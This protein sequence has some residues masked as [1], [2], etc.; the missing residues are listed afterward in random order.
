MV[1]FN[2]KINAKKDIS[3]GDICKKVSIKNTITRKMKKLKKLQKEET[4][5]K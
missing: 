2:S 5:L 3:K 4:S 1:T